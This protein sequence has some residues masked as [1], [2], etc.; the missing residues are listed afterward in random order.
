VFKKPHK[1]NNAEFSVHLHEFA[2]V[3]GH[4]YVRLVVY[5]M[6]DFVS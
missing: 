1:E 4:F 6:Q 2:C 5:F 3:H